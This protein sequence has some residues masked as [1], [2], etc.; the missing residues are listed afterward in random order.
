MKGG[1]WLPE[2]EGLRRA[3]RWLAAQ[4]RHDAAAIEEASRRFD[5]SPVEEG[6]LLGRMR[7]PG[8]PAEPEEH[9]RA[10]DVP[11]EVRA[12]HECFVAWFSGA[13]AASDA[14]F[15]AHFCCRLAEDFE[16]VL[17]GGRRLARQ[18]LLEDLR[19]AHGSN[20]AFRIQV[21][22][23]RVRALGGGAVWLVTYEEWQRNARRSTPPDNGRITSATLVPDAQ[24]PYGLKWVHAHETWLPA[25]VVVA[26][27]F[28]F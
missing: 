12:L 6:F 27:P 26:D 18:A 17:P 1:S 15:D 11:A 10:L 20:P 16:I 5:L 21:R 8:G 7:E 13:C 3:V 19:A 14:W 24:C 25:E 23:V 22:D 28:D 2:G 9:M 4:R